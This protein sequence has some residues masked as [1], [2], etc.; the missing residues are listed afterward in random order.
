MPTLSIPKKPLSATP[1][2]KIIAMTI[3]AFWLLSQVT[4]W[5]EFLEVGLGRVQLPSYATD[6]LAQR[7]TSRTG[8]TEAT[9]SSWHHWASFIT[10]SSHVP[11]GISQL[12]SKML[13]ST[14]SSLFPSCP[15]LIN[16]A[17]KNTQVLKCLLSQKLRNVDIIPGLFIISG[18]E[19]TNSLWCMSTR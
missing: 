14:R 8:A 17:G 5:K 18:D 11:T 12:L 2:L 4:K 16:T 19:K 3:D 7:M 13:K 15:S 9:G 10:V 6:Q 1:T